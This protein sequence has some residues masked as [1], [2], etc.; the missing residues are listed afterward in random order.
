MTKPQKQI[1]LKEIQLKIE[2]YCAY[3]DRCKFEVEQKLKSF[4]IPLEDIN[5]I[6]DRLI[7]E[8]FIDEIRYAQSYTR[9]SY[10]H[11]KWGRN[12]IKANLIA[13]K[14]DNKITNI[15]FN[16]I[17]TEEYNL[18]IFHEL[19]KKWPSIKANSDFDKKNKLIRFGIS[20]GYEFDIIS[21][22]LEQ[23]IKG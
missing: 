10:R 8:K 11:K 14:I 20:R 23:Q 7:N 19:S 22:F 9:G 1:S 17:D 12:K 15:A 2:Q 16:E 3:Q 6:M 21:S 18:M 13:K 5:N 4:H